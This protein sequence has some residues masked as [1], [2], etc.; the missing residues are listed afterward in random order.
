MDKKNDGQSKEKGAKGSQSNVPN[1][2]GAPGKGDGGGATGGQDKSKRAP[3]GE[4]S[5]AGG[6][7]RRK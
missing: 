1:K 7:Q 6:D 4:S 5:R 2:Q 3:G